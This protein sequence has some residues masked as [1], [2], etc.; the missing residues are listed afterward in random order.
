[1]M[2]RM[3]N[4]GYIYIYTHA[5]VVSSVGKCCMLYMIS[6]TLLLVAIL[7]QN[8]CVLIGIK[9]SFFPLKQS[10]SSLARLTFGSANSWLWWSCAHV[11]CGRSQDV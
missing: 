8:P 3:H 4:L 11:L 9:A 5:H 6:S 2:T 1:M 7:D 10:F